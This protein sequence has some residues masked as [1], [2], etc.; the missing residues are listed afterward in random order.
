MAEF[1]SFKEPKGDADLIDALWAGVN[2][3]EGWKEL[4]IGD[5]ID[6]ITGNSFEG[7][8]F[9]ETGELPLIKNKTVKQQSP[10]EYIDSD[11]DKKY[12]V[13][14]QDLLVTMDGEF[15]PRI[16]KLGDAALNQRVCKIV[17][18]ENLSKMYLR[19]SLQDPLELLHSA[20]AGTTV[21]HLSNYDFNRIDLPVPPVD[22]QRRIASVLYSV[23][24]QVRSLHDRH[25]ELTRVKHGLMQDLLTGNTR[26]TPKI[27]VQKEVEWESEDLGNLLDKE[28]C[29]ERVGKFF[30]LING[31]KPEIAESG[32]H[33]YLNV[34]TLLGKEVEYTNDTDVPFASEKDTLMIVDGSRSGKVFRG[35]EG[36]VSS[37]MSALKPTE[38]INPEY[39]YQLL[40]N[41]YN[42]INAATIGSS[43]PH[44]DKT[45][46][47]S[48]ELFIPQL[49]E[50]ERIASVLYTI[51]EMISRTND[52]MDKYERLK[53]GL[54]QDL[55]SGDIRTPEDLEVIEDII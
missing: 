26:V 20:T 27:E 51:D 11:F 32:E 37:T 35:K 33:L 31:Q 14:N 18:R 17:P 13:K 55:L 25:D 12:L 3:P 24:E 43:I 46:V 36:A 21:K 48:L 9:G 54:M 19:Y 40:S 16:W 42:L 22:E 41:Q 10:E 34:D 28:D 47:K 52:L 15:V 29:M 45:L 50:Q 4:N 39:L 53:Q 23:D 5:N 2:M 44:T 49:W 7:D 8:R 1:T 30:E 6:V 38:D